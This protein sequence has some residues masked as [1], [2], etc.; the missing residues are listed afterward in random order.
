[1][2]VRMPV[3]EEDSNEIAFVGIGVGV[4]PAMM[5]VGYIPLSVGCIP[6]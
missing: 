5:S 1:M 6:V 3:L 2:E 4:G